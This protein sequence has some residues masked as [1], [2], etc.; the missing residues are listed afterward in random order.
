MLRI[1][2]LV[3]AL[4]CNASF[5]QEVLEGYVEKNYDGVRYFSAGVGGIESCVW[6]EDT[7]WL[8]MDHDNREHLLLK[9]ETDGDG[10]FWSLVSMFGKDRMSGL[11]RIEAQCGKTP[12]Q[13][14]YLQTTV[15]TEPMMQGDSETSL[16]A[17]DDW[18][19]A[20]EGS[21]MESMI[22]LECGHWWKK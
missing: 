17:S 21:Y 5:A 1:L 12:L 4:C 18:I 15:F 2:G 22:K 8:L 14:R 13:Y 3:A 20:P 9:V 19:E 16:P 7:D 6:A 11:Y 10:Q